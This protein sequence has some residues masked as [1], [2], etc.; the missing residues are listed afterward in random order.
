MSRIFV[1]GSL[2]KGM[3]N[4]HQYLEDKSIFIQKGFVKGA[5][6]SIK[7]VEY[8]ALLEGDS[9]VLGEI[10]EIDEVVE[11]QLDKLEG[12]SPYSTENEYEKKIRDIYDEDMQFLYPLSVYMFNMEKD[13]HKSIIKNKIPSG[14]YVAY[15]KTKR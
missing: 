13:T 2:R 8:P 6:F 4:Y 10:Y 12:Y 7:G 5:L 11:Q 3:Y 14:D 9:Y 1:Y 15:Q